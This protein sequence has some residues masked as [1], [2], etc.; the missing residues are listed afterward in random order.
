MG[1]PPKN[2]LGFSGAQHETFVLEGDHSVPG[3]MDMLVL[4]YQNRNGKGLPT[5]ASLGKATRPCQNKAKTPAGLSF[6]KVLV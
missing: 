2:S 5:P 1:R 4:E 3:E 6:V